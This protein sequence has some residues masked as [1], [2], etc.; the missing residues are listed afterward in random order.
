MAARKP[1]TK[2]TTKMPV[3]T[4]AGPKGAAKKSGRA[5]PKLEKSSPALL[6]AFEQTMAALPMAQTRQV[7][8][9]PAAFANGHMFAGI[10][11]DTF[12][13]RLPEAERESFRQ[14]VS[15]RQWEPMPGRPMREYVVVPAR[16][17]EAPAD[18]NPWLGKAL[19]HVQSLPPK[20]AKTR[21]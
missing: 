12:F 14:T 7:F 10:Q 18:L 5:M 13:L 11:N 2:K 21:R 6:Q 1:A 19:A 16:L 4:K 15:A 3:A 8:G 17:I 9:S 20:A